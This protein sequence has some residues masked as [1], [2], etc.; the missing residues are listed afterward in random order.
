MD[1]HVEV[2]GT[3]SVAT[4]PDQAVLRL[5]LVGEAKD[6]AGALAALS[7]VTAALLAELDE[8]GVPEAD[9]R[10]SSLSLDEHWDDHGRRR[11]HAARQGLT[12]R[13][14]TVEGAG[15]VVSRAA[16]VAGG[17]LRVRGLEWTTSDPTAARSEARA[18][19]WADA[20]ATAEQLASLAGR[21]LGE[22]VR[23]PAAGADPGQD[24][25]DGAVR[26][27]AFEPQEA[28]PTSPG[29]TAVTCSLLV[30]WRLR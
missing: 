9:R 10:T 20:R 26:A 3:G 21:E 2:S 23:V 5:Q 25:V 19:A 30:R 8:A 15:E 17:A 16:A 4:A 1:D 13:L 28:L 6:V 27:V 12:V 29:S 18:A 7:T 14:P 11:G 24:E 22:A